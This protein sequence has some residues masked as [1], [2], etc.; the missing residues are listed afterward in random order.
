MKSLVKKKVGTTAAVVGTIAWPAAGLWWAHVL[1]I[2]W[3]WFIVPTFGAPPL[4]LANA[5]GVSLVAGMFKATVQSHTF[6][7]DDPENDTYARAAAGFLTPL[8][9]LVVGAIVR[10][11]T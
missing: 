5:I 9:L 8:F 6:D 4:T 10:S 7:A 3:A 1:T 2:L 11:F